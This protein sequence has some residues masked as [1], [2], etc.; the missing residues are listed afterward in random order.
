MLAR[1]A[2]DWPQTALLV[3][4]VA[5]I[6]ALWSTPFVYPLKMLV[7]FF[8][9]LSHGIAAMLTGGEIVRIELDARQGGLCVTRGG[10]RFLIT[11]AGYLGSML[12]GGAILVAAARTNFDRQIM[13]GL[14]ALMLVAAVLWVRPFISF[15][16]VFVLLTGVAMVAASRW[17][18]EQGNDLLLR[19]IGLT[20]CLYAIA[21]IKSDAL[22]RDVPGSDAWVI[23]DSLPFINGWIVG[24]IWILLSVVASGFFIWIAAQGGPA[25]DGKPTTA[26]KIR[27]GSPGNEW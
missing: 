22:D 6:Y 14:G 25:P 5:V 10:W 15:A 8:H 11:S 3:A 18:G 23:A 27:P 2:I 7:V 26:Q 1:S 19:L 16:L 13:A 24:A 17:L 9:E 21:D 12:W 20:S 4:M